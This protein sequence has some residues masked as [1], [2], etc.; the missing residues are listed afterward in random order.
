M[1]VG[2]Q[3]GGATMTGYT[4]HLDDSKDVFQEIPALRLRRRFPADQAVNVYR[5]PREGWQKLHVHHSATANGCG[6]DQVPFTKMAISHAELE[7]LTMVRHHEH[8]M[9]AAG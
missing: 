7:S 1:I 9:A 2:T 5:G 6:M 4:V 8:S 3:S